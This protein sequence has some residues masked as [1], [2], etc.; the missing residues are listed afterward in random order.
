MKG[1]IILRLLLVVL[2]IT[3]LTLGLFAKN[4][5]TILYVGIEHTKIT[6]LLSI[7]IALLIIA[8]S[9]L[10]Y[11]KQKGEKEEIVKTYKFTPKGIIREDNKELLESQLKT[12]LNT[13]RD[14]GVSFTIS[15]HYNNS[16]ENIKLI[17]TLWISNRQDAQT[18]RSLMRVICKDWCIEE[19]KNNLRKDYKGQQM[20]SYGGMASIKNIMTCLFKRLFQ[21][22]SK[23]IQ[24]W[25]EL[26]LNLIVSYCLTIIP[27]ISNIT[28]HNELD[29]T[30][31]LT[32]I[33]L[34]QTLSTNVM[35]S[36]DYEKILRHIGIFG[37]TGSG[38]ST[39]AATLIKNIYDYMKIP[40]I[41]LDWHNEY[42]R[43]LNQVGI[44]RTYLYR[45]KDLH[46]NP[47]FNLEKSTLDTIVDIFASALELSSPQIYYLQMALERMLEHRVE[48]SLSRLK[49]ILQEEIYEE[50]RSGREAL[51]ALLRKL[52]ILNRG[53]NETY[54]Y[55]K[56][57][58]YAEN[59]LFRRGIHILRLADIRNTQLRR[60]Y[61]VMTIRLIYEKLITLGLTNKPRVIVV[62]EEAHNIF[63]RDGIFPS[64][65]VP[66][67]RKY[68]LGFIIISQS[69]S[70]LPQQ[71]ILNINTK[72]IHTILSNRDK[73]ILS[74]IY[75]MSKDDLDK[76]TN[77]APGEAYLLTTN[78][79][80]P[81]PLHILLNN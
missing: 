17:L 80:Y 14:Y 34:L 63:S 62:V 40:V 50:T 52:S 22:K 5:L 45:P 20:E 23:N 38:K 41:I 33:R 81:L 12:L 15:A 71:V 72:I 77:L 35:L 60:L 3:L 44:D 57:G 27:S 9:F 2:S 30:I 7:P 1:G 51:Y 47:L 43:L 59:L 13:L 25:S 32:N 64:T 74:E 78:L 53:F 46:I 73:K 79:K 29:N 4:P 66:E 37:T 11:H 76:L 28:K 26:P 67:V 55:M 69:L 56:V 18:L 10:R 58:L 42:E 65:L 31:P 16:L 61:A 6:L 39:T 49:R 70:L 19:L 24:L 21:I 36:L 75:S 68:G 8:F 48:P 54:D